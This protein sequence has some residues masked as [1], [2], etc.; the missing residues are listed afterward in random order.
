MSE[1]FAW[2]RSE[3]VTLARDW[4][5]SAL[6]GIAFLV[7]LWD[8]LLVPLPGHSR[9]VSLAVLGLVLL[10]GLR[11]LRTALT[12]G[13]RQAELCE[14]MFPSLWAAYQFLEPD[15]LSEDV[16]HFYN[17]QTWQFEIDGRDGV[18]RASISVTNMHTDPTEFIPVKVSGDSPVLFEDI[19]AYFVDK[20][21][22]TKYPVDKDDMIYDKP[23]VKCFRVN[24]P[25]PLQRGDTFEAEV[26]CKWPGTFSKRDDF[27][28]MA[29]QRFTQGV[30]RATAKVILPSPPRFY[31]VAIWE[32]NKVPR[33]ATGAEGIRARLEGSTI[34]WEK[35]EPRQD[36]V[37]IVGFR[38]EDLPR[39][40]A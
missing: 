30:R 27:V 38:R 4:V 40:S 28:F 29:F 24:F 23:Y 5:T 2:A 25:S 36:C 1:R 18:Y 8:R 20:K 31:R 37:Y 11:R 33:L 7:L 17:E 34:V 32:K 6:G 13:R 39:A 12:A 16:R 26:V 10:L 3:T 9:I 14:A 35:E 15:P 19:E 21:T 22:N